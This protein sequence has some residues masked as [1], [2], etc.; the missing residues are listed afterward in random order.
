MRFSGSGFLFFCC[1]CMA[2]IACNNKPAPDKPLSL[3]INEGYFAEIA[4]HRTGL[5]NYFRS[6]NSPL[7]DSMKNIF[8]EIPYYD[9]DT[10]FRVV[11]EFEKIDNGPVFKIAASG[12]IADQYKTMGLLHFQ[13][14]NNRFVLEVYRNESMKGEG[15]DNYFIPF[16][17]KTNG[18]ETYAGGRY[19]DIPAIKGEKVILD[20]NYAYQPYCVYNYDYSC[21]IPPLQNVVNTEIRAGERM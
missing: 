16:F 19:L 2:V 12:N 6:E 20:F 7:S 5:N 14:N 15:A 1:I 13:L 18:I 10:N 3:E 4:Q 9:V 17:D 8:T 11:A 21:P